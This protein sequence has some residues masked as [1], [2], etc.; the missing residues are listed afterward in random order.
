MKVALVGVLALGLSGC[1]DGGGSGVVA[2]AGS[3]AEVPS[4]I[5]EAGC[6]QG[7][8]RCSGPVL[9]TCTRIGWEPMNTLAGPEE[10]AAA[11][12]E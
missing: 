1:G 10:C 4:L 3:D 6:V 2:D 9:E 7:L 11:L 5:K 12:V 8:S